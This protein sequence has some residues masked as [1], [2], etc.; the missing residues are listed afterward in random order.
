MVRG[1]TDLLR[2]RR[3]ARRSPPRERTRP[4]GAVFRSGDG[5]PRRQEAARS[6]EF[7]I[8]LP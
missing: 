5:L 4:A 2:C 8:N 6:A 1:G 3:V 7:A